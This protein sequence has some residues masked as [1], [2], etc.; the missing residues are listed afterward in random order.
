M[1]IRAKEKSSSPDINIKASKHSFF[2]Y[3]DCTSGEG[4]INSLLP[5]L[6]KI[7]DAEFK[8]YL[9]FILK[10]C[11]NVNRSFSDAVDFL[12]IWLKKSPD[13][14]LKKLENA[15]LKKYFNRTEYGHDGDQWH[16]PRLLQT[17]LILI[18]KKSITADKILDY[19]FETFD[20]F[21]LPDDFVREVIGYDR[22]EVCIKE[23]PAVFKQALLSKMYEFV[24]KNKLI[25]IGFHSRRYLNDEIQANGAIKR[26]KIKPGKQTEGQELIAYLK[27]NEGLFI[28]PSFRLYNEHNSCAH[29]P[30]F[31][32]VNNY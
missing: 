25:D 5:E 16:F 20:F 14:L 24:E 12:S 32:G 23:S 3:L 6:E 8:S 13:S 18:E 21:N 31:R 15:E 17:F 29:E 11:I 30:N 2:Y 4:L 9:G 1:P 10:K 19:L 28:Y 22:L 27:Q 26:I 7:S